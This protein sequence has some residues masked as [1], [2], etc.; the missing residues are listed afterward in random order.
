MSELG[1]APLPPRGGSG[2]RTRVALACTDCGARNY[3]T[4]R[5]PERKGQLSLKK[6]CPTC[7]RHTIHKETK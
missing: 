1:S 7:K 5:K 2:G 6:F 4:T 3:D